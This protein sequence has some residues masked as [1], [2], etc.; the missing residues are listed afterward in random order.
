M[1]DDVSMR[2]FYDAAQTA[3]HDLDLRHYNPRE[4]ILY[5]HPETWTAA[6]HDAS[7]D[8]GLIS[9][10]ELPDG[11]TVLETAELPEGLVVA[12]CV[13]RFQHGE[14]EAIAFAEVETDA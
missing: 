3:L 13:E 7:D 5:A 9:A 10:D 4:A 6:K 2:A 12:V 1:S 14:G 8:Y 11:T